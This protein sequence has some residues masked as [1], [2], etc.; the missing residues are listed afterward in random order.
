MTERRDAA[1]ASAAPTGASREGA[2]VG[3]YRLTR[4][5]GHGGMGVVYEAVHATIARR[6]AVKVLVA[7]GGL[8]PDSLAR[9]TREARV[10]SEIRH[11]GLVQ[12]FDAG[13]L[14]DGAP[15][16]LM[17]LLEGET[18]RA[19]LSTTG[20]IDPDTAA[21]IVRQ[22]ASALAAVH[23]RGIVHRDVKPENVMLVA[24]D[25]IE[26]GERVKLLDFGIA[27][28]IKDGDRV[29]C[30]G[31]I[32]GTPTYM[33]PEQCIPEGTPTTATDL[34]ALGIL[35]FEMLA[36]EPPFH[37]AAPLVL[38]GHVFGQPP[39]ARIEHEETR[40][41]VAS[42]L[43]KDPARRPSA[44]A[45]ASSGSLFPARSELRHSPGAF[46]ATE[47]VSS[48]APIAAVSSGGRARAPR[49]SVVV[50]ALA[51]SL[52]LGFVVVVAARAIRRP[53]RAGNVAGMVRIDGS[54]FTMGRSDV[55]ISAECA[56]VGAQCQRATLDREQPAHRVRLSPFFID[57]HEATNADAL[58]W[59]TAAP[60]AIRPDSTTHV[61]RYVVDRASGALLVDLDATYSG[62]ALDGETVVMRPGFAAK[63]VVQITWTGA[64]ALCAWRGKRLPTEAEWE[65]AARGMTSRRFP[66]GDDEPRCADVV[67]ARDEGLACE[68]MPRGAADVDDGAMDLTPERVHALAGNV[69]EWVEDAFLGPYYA[70]C[71]DCIDP[72]QLPASGAAV[73][74][75]VV[76]GGAWSKQLFTHATARSRWNRDAV[77]G[78]IGVR[79]AAS[80]P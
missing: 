4:V 51:V 15:Y 13:A 64:R 32:I 39:L 65:R 80:V 61:A 19:R 42:L 6:A 73:D 77:A 34:Y 69:S 28:S 70:D 49:R 41:L 45:L 33:A 74:V 40:R 57:A 48:L 53:A 11:P 35:Y 22:L 31:A 38:R 54:E 60:I 1:A 9:F 71:G 46:S 16:L 3:G 12:I 8:G 21:R 55:E 72:V 30:D 14:E 43:E 26:G 75:R 62:L 10:A 56:R 58:A 52:A 66:W 2:A 37:G 25:A 17:E 24:D 18:L 67:V 44:S 7:R 78:A 47:R 79:C 36:G 68:A 50:T 63:P 23:A 20:R 27:R 76:R 29:T 59:L 5:L